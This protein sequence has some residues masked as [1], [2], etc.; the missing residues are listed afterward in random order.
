MRIDLN[1]WIISDTH[2]G[3][4]RIIELAGRP[5]NHDEIMIRNWQ[6]SIKDSDMVL[7]LGDL[8]LRW[9]K[10]TSLVEQVRELPGEKYMIWGNHD[11]NPESFYN[12]LGFTMIDDFTA[13][14][15]AE[16][17]H[18]LGDDFSDH[19][20]RTIM[21]SH[22]PRIEPTLE[23][24]INIHGHIHTS[25]WPPEASL[26]KD[27]R[28]VSIEYMS[29]MPVRLYD[30]LFKRAYQARADATKVNE[31]EAQRVSNGVEYDL[32]KF[33]RKRQNANV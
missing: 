26:D 18:N 21:F 3:H 1:T 19:N 25:G 5:E 28:N 7:H 31:Y 23:W 15:N 33:L 2:F 16:I 11:D 17:W 22:Y 30:I 29:Y 13:V 32:Y 24:D 9:G 14:F 8:G 4:N 6:D 12:D 10:P 20:I 27:Y